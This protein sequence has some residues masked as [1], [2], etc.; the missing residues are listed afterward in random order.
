MS[1]HPLCGVTSQIDSGL[2]PYRWWH[3]LPAVPFQS[4]LAI[5][6]SAKEL[7]SVQTGMSS[8]DALRDSLRAK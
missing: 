1:Y 5:Q 4:C 3:E 6:T 8:Q 7:S 2:F